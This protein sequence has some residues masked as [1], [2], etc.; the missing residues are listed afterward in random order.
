MNTVLLFNYNKL[1]EYILVCVIST[2]TPLLYNNALYNNAYKLDTQTYSINFRLI[3][4]NS[5][6]PIKAKPLFHLVE[7]TADIKSVPEA[8]KCILLLDVAA[9]SGGILF[10]ETQRKHCLNF[11]IIEELHSK[12]GE[13]HR[14]IVLNNKTGE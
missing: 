5:E 1:I 2:Q 8:P 14:C 13:G 12:T 9:V 6:L 4:S 10:D 11:R 3:Q 7:T